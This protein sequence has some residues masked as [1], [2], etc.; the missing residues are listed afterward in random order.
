[1]ANT[2]E[3]I[4]TAK[5]SATRVLKGIGGSLVKVAKTA[6][7]A[8]VALVALGLASVKAFASFESAFAGV[9]KTVDATEAEFKILSDA[10]RQMAKE[11]PASTVEISKVAEAAGQLGIQKENILGFTRTMVDLGN[12][13]N[14]SSDMAATALARLANITQ[15]SQDQFSNMGSA[16]VELGNNFA[17]TEA[18]IV[19]MALQLAGAGTIIGLSEAEILGFS[20]AL[21][22]VGIRAERGGTAFQRVMVEI[23]KAAKSGGKTLKDFAE[24]A[25][26]SAEDFKKSFETDAAGALV[27]FVEGLDRVSDSG[28]DI[29]KVLENLGFANVRVRD[30]LLRAS[31]AGDLMREAIEASSEAWIKNTALTIEAQKRYDTMNSKLKIAWNRIKDLGVVIGAALSPFVIQAA[32]DIGAFADKAGKA[33]VLLPEILKLSL[34]TMKALF[35]RYFQDFDFFENLLG[36]A[37]IFAVEMLQGFG[38]MLIQMGVISLKAGAIIFSP[39]AVGFQFIGGK[40]RFAF[41]TLMRELATA[42]NIFL[43]KM[44]EFKI[45]DKIVAPAKTFKELWEANGKNV[46]VIVKSMSDNFSAIGDGFS[47]TFATLKGAMG[48]AANSPEIQALLEQIE[49]LFVVGEKIKLQGIT[50]FDAHVQA[51]LDANET[52]TPA[53]SAFA[54]FVKSS[55]T[56]VG[57]TI[58]D[59]WI[60]SRDA[61]GDM[62][63]E[64]IVEGK[65]FADALKGF[66]KDI[67]KSFLSMVARMLAEKVFFSLLTGGLGGGG[68]IL[69]GIGK[70]FGFA[71]G[72]IVPGGLNPVSAANGGVF[73][74]PTLAIIGDNPARQE[75]VIPMRGGKVPVQLMG[76]TGNNIAVKNLNIL[77][78]AQLDESLLNAP[79]S[80]YRDFAKKIL[81]ELNILGEQGHTTTLKKREAFF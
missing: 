80:F 66:F 32:E 69:S 6:K 79:Q 57:T 36:N 78:G 21:S 62:V 14:L 19:N 16:I 60:D 39:L 35:F 43:P 75:A 46:E 28:K 33:F 42:A 1:M 76:N 45:E 48:D 50:L 11:I 38:N 65:S 70:I 3:I 29:F 23:A 27:D 44:F 15:L 13:T 54:E 64:S 52:L 30:T 55:F 63:A 73:T 59:I 8:G 53:I 51:F 7:I 81:D 5:D 18:E 17:T 12:T 31:G 58:Q 77:P 41:I 24:V 56:D 4:I 47:A 71:K 40:I 72:G 10:I 2:V 49:A 26:I 67:L 25:G 9:R 61:F 34:D 22:S 68:G 37:A 74:S 20:T